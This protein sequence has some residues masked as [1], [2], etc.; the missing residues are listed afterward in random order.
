VTI[1][2]NTIQLDIQAGSE[3]NTKTTPHDP[4]GMMSFAPRSMTGTIYLTRGKPEH[5]L[6]G[7]FT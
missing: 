4:S 1:E 5:M 7:S 6:K 2:E 3:W